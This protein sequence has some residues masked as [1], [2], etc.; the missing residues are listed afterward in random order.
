MRTG[1]NQKGVFNIQAGM[2]FIMPDM[3]EL[4][5][6]GQDIEAYRHPWLILGKS[7]DYVEIV[8]CTT[9]SSNIEGKHNSHKLD[10]EDVTDIINSCPP[11]DAMRER[12]NGVSM[13]TYKYF[14]KKELFSHTLRICNRN[15]PQR[16]FQTEGF[17]SLCLDERTLKNLRTEVRERALKS[18][19]CKNDPFRCYEA[20]GYLDDLEFGEAVP[21]WFTRD[22]YRKNFGWEHI[23]SVNPN[24]VYPCEKDMAPYEKQDKKLVEIVRRRDSGMTDSFIRNIRNISENGGFG[25]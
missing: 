16:N 21:E 7:D 2:A 17:K 23:K 25:L 4:L 9:L 1:R 11:L 12:I 24:K 8:M 20:E 18:K 15:T 3:G 10:F 5:E 6:E 19:D 22:W 13:D 14:P